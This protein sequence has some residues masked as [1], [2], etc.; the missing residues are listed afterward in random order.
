MVGHTGIEPVFMS[1]W[2]T[3]VNPA[4]DLY[5]IDL[6]LFYTNKNL[7]FSGPA[8]ETRTRHVWLEIKNVTTTPM[9]DMA[10]PTKYDLATFGV[11]GQRSNQNWAT[12]PY[13]TL[14]TEL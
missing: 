10:V 8:Y 9:P 1:L 12:E 2:E 5:K 6:N 7:N 14:K 11:T 13:L 3:C 4:H